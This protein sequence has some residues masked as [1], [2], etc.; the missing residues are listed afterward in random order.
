MLKQ[1]EGL[2]ANARELFRKRFLEIKTKILR[3]LSQIKHENIRAVIDA[4]YYD[5]RIYIL[6]EILKGKEI[7]L[8]ELNMQERE[9]AIARLPS[10]VAYI[11]KMGY[12][13]PTWEESSVV[14]YKHESWK[15]FVLEECLSRMKMNEV[16]G[17]KSNS[18][19]ASRFE[20]QPAALPS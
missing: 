2:V 6:K 13:Y 12:Y 19:T 16:F 10:V 11:H 14:F 8:R 1:Q 17:L 20:K 9:I 5:E 15:S 4:V 7:P 3:D 18:S